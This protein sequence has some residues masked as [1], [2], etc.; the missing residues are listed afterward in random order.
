M[1]SAPGPVELLARLALQSDRYRDDIDFQEA[2]DNVLGVP[3]YDA[4]PAL[5]ALIKRSYRSIAECPKTQ[6]E[7][8]LLAELHAAIEAA[9]PKGKGQ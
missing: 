2:V 9:E 4:A 6:R 3:V 7:I 5:L 8:D 1:S